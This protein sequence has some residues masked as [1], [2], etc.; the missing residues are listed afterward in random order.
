MLPLG[1]LVPEG[2]IGGIV[3]EAGIWCYLILSPTGE[4]LTK[5]IPVSALVSVGPSPTSHRHA[6]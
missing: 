4:V 1:A 2:R 6:S 3:Q 5:P